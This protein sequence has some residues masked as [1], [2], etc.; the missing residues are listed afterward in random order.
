MCREEMPHKGGQL[1]ER[2]R[3]LFRELQAY[4]NLGIVISIKTTAPP[5][6]SGHGRRADEKEHEPCL[7]QQSKEARAT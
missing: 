6:A 4:I 5:R 3:L 1:S 7:V 2:S